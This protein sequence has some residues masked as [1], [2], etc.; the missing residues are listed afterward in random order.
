MSERPEENTAEPTLKQQRQAWLQRMSSLG[1]IA[2]ALGMD[3]GTGVALTRLRTMAEPGIIGSGGPVGW[4]I[5]AGD[6]RAKDFRSVMLA[7]M[8]DPDQV[9]AGLLM[10]MRSGAEA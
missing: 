5:I 7:Q 6:G 1:D 4:R 10:A 9:I 3:P 2:A 8:S